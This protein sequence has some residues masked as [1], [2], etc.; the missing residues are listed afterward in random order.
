MLELVEPTNA[1]NLT[2]EFHK[3]TA[4]ANI[5]HP[6]EI[7]RYNLLNK[8]FAATFQSTLSH[9]FDVNQSDRLYAVAT[10]PGH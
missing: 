6:G 9:M 7:K 4:A 1:L 10:F 3:S 2:S 5:C 8:G